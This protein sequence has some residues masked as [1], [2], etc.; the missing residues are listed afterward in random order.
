MT[1][2]SQTSFFFYLIFFTFDL[3]TCHWIQLICDV[4]AVMRSLFIEGQV[5]WG[6][7]ERWHVYNNWTTLK[8]RI[9]SLSTLSGDMITFFKPWRKLWHQAVS[10]FKVWLKT[11]IFWFF[12][13]ALWWL[14]TQLLI[15][16]TWLTCNLDKVCQELILHR[17]AAAVS[18]FSGFHSRREN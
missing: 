14:R 4:V 11:I 8:A 18:L 5:W 15:Q 1:C 17:S 3:R 6:H 2:P 10:I 9:I 16:W 13:G 12:W 7:E